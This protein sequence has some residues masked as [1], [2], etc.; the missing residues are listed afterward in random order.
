MA[1][2]AMVVMS[3]LAAVEEGKEAI[4]EEGGIAALV[5][6]IE[7]GSLKGK[8]FAVMTLLQ[9]CGESVRNRGLLVREGGI[10]PLAA[11]ARYLAKAKHKLAE[12][13]GNV[14]MVIFPN[15][16]SELVFF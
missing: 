6:V 12:V 5:E 2:K 11:L 13:P 8:E 15:Y 4:V 9:L 16:V 3:S 10:P 1:E 7:D 14:D